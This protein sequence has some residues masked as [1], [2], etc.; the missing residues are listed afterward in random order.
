MSYIYKITNNINGKIYIGKTMH[1]IE[2]R[3]KE[4]LANVK[5]EDC[6]NR[7]LYKAINKYGVKNFSIEEI[8]E[9]SDTILSDREKY[10]IEY[11]S[12]FKNGYNATKGGDGSPYIDRK[13][14]IETYKQIQNCKKTAEILNI[15]IDS[16]YKILKSNDI[17]R[18]SSQEISKECNGKP[19]YMLDK[20]D[21]R[22]L[23]AFTSMKEAAKYIQEKTNNNTDLRGMA[24]HIR[25]VCQGKRKTAYGYSWKFLNYKQ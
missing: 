5:K 2:Q 21:L 1:S 25:E 15:H 17:E 20:K 11:Y 10:W 7:P 14:V 13:L 3:W 9:C 8:E 22:I 6:K 12:S 19:V 4:H 18:K 16:V 23:K 24:S